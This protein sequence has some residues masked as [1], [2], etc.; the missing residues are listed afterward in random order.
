MSDT[1][2]IARPYAKAIFEYAH[3]A[4]KLAPWSAILQGLAQAVLDPQANA[5][6]RNPRAKIEQQSQL[7]SIFSQ[8]DGFGAEVKAIENLILL[9]AK[10]KRLLLLPDICAQYEVLRAEQEKILTVHVQT[11]S[12]LTPAQQQ[13]LIQSLSQRLQRQITLDV[14]I[15]ESLLG[16]AIIRAGDLV[17]DGSVRG[18]LSKLATDLAA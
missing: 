18:K 2:T 12:A 3:A 13:N 7:L 16:G 10:N 1:T 17:I 11:F 8:T 6:I 4:G 15:D 14:T 5:F 9:L